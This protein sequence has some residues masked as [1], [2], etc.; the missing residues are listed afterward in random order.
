MNLRITNKIWNWLVILVL[1]LMLGRFFTQAYGRALTNSN[2][3]MGDQG[4]FLQLGLDLREHG[5]LTDGTRNPLYAAFLAAIA[6]RDWTY[7]S[8]AKLLSITFGMLAIAAVFLL[9]RRRFNTFTGLVTAYLLSINVE[10]TVHSATALTESLLVLTFILAWFAM[11]KALDDKD[12]WQ[13]WVLAG[14]LSGLSYLAKGS[15]QSMAVTF[16]LTAFLIYR[17]EIFRAKGLWAFLA[18]YVLVAGPY[19]VYNTVHFGSP[20]FNYAMTHQVWMEHWTDWHPD[21]L[22]DL[23]TAFSYIQ[24]HSPAEIV[25]REWT[26]MKALRNILIKT[27]WPTRTLKVDRFLLSPIS[28]YSLALLAVIPLVFWRSSSR[29]Y[30]RRNLGAV[31]LTGLTIIVFFLAFAWYVPIIAGTRFQLPVIPLIFIMLTHIVSLLGQNIA[32]RGPWAKRLVILAAL[33]VVFYQARWAIRTNTEPMENLLTYNLFEQDRQFGLNAATPLEWVVSGSPDTRTAAWGPSGH[34]LPIWAYSDR[35]N[36]KRYPPGVDTIPALTEN[37]VSRNVD[38]VIVDPD[39]VARHRK[40]LK[41]QFPSDDTRIELTGIPAG[42]AL[43]FAYPNIPCQ[44]CVFR[45]VDSSPPRQAVDYQI[46]EAIRLAGYDLDDTQ[47]QAGDT[48]HLTLHW[49][50][51]APV[52]R[53][54]TTFTQLLGPDFQLHGQL[55]GQPVNNLWPTG[56]WQSGDHL[57]DRYDIPIDANAPAG[58]YQILV[59]M[60]DLQTGQ[61]QPVTQSEAPVPDNAI[62]LTTITV[63][64]E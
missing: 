29:R 2:S 58:E 31:Y 13:Y 30:I 3:A 52:D 22:D 1:I 17:F 40:L 47:F 43:S 20:T 27:L 60:Y 10:F 6:Q 51:T 14:V 38:F 48:V 54:Y 41:K 23:P 5:I 12:M 21:A 11:L 57:S 7:F 16:L 63:A 44:W 26:G 24:T 32:G 42:W 61:R 53:D 18:A 49:Q 64:R 33:I 45:L 56:R 46:G 28:G 4:A 59:G 62:Y 34:S 39:M 25:G 55:D 8:Q 50:A 15:G 36:F 19:W 9:G 35:I 37:L